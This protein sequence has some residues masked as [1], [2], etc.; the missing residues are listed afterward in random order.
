MDVLKLPGQA[1]DYLIVDALDECPNTTAM[2]SP[3]ENVLK[4]VEQ[5]ID[6]QLQNLRICVT[7]LPEIDIKALLGD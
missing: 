5:L 3:R 7:S 6:S 4:L 2:P 1:P